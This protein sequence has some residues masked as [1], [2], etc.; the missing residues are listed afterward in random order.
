MFRREGADFRDRT[1]S[2]LS[3]PYKTTTPPTSAGWSRSEPHTTESSRSNHGGG[4]PTGWPNGV[5][6]VAPQVTVDPTELTALRRRIRVVTV[7]H[8]QQV[9]AA[10]R[11]NLPASGNRDGSGLQF[12][13]QLDPAWNSPHTGERATADRKAAH[14]DQIS[15]GLRLL[16]PDVRRGAPFQLRLLPWIRSPWFLMTAPSLHRQGGSSPSSPTPCQC[17]AA[18]IARQRGPDQVDIWWAR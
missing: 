3:R 6:L 13:V 12:A 14:I 8:M 2:D 5:W 4:E 18:V 16:K 9:A 15:G 1:L 11:S 17:Q 7:A 10:K